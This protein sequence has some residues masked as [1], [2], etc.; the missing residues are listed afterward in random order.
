MTT[1][2]P[3]LVASRLSR[4]G[5]LGRLVLSGAAMSC[6]P[7]WKVAAAGSAER[8]RFK[9]ALTPGSIG[10]RADARQCLELAQRHG[11]DAV[12]P[13]AAFL[14]G[15]SD[16]ELSEWLGRMKA[17]GISFAAAGLPVDFRG[18][19]AKFT[20]GLEALPGVAA[21]L[22]RAGVDRVGTWLS[23]GHQ[24]L[25]YLQNFRQHAQRLRAVAKIL[26]D[27]GQRLGLEYVGTPTARHSRRYPFVHCLAEL[28]ELRAEIGAA[29]VGCVLDSWHWWT[30]GETAADLLTLRNADVVSVDLNDAPT[31]IPVE[32]QQD[33][34]R[35]LPCATGVI[36]VGAFLGALVR[37]GYDGPIRA[38]PFNKPLN[39]LDD[40][41]ACAAVIAAM[42]KAVAQLG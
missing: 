32:Q 23:P 35:E 26:Q 14:A 18:D 15:L 9:L 12:E 41:A 17:Q 19:N 11:F 24:E 25:T 40:E 39:E 6:F 36:P 20:A 16:A 31:G 7:R 30:A 28:Q 1:S 5:F 27:H 29:N 10:V 13:N 38:E 34:Q 21:A 37:I 2:P 3:C 33:G 8:P 4:R 22:R 42:R